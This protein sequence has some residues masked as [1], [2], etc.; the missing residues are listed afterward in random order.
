MSNAIVVGQFHVRMLESHTAL[1]ATI[2]YSSRFCLSQLCRK[3]QQRETLRLL[4]G[5]RVRSLEIPDRHAQQSSRFAHEL[6]AM[7]RHFSMLIFSRGRRLDSEINR[8]ALW[9]VQRCFFSN[10]QKRRK[11]QFNVFGLIIMC[12]QCPINVQCFFRAV[13]LLTT[14]CKPHGT[15]IN[16]YLIFRWIERTRDSLCHSDVASMAC[17]FTCSSQVK[18]SLEPSP[19][20]DNPFGAVNLPWPLEDHCHSTATLGRLRRL[21]R[22]QRPWSTDIVRLVVDLSLYAL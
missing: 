7:S 9:K 4:L 16:S 10:K 11:R 5:Y 22:P 19:F 17:C 1:T 2:S 6:I 8:T 12:R 21:Y 18:R 3:N 20:N 14:D 15:M 13:K